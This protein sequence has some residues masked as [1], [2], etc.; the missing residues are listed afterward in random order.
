MKKEKVEAA[1]E[2]KTEEAVL[3]IRDI[4]KIEEKTNWKINLKPKTPRQC[5]QRKTERVSG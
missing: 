4:L 2:E 3:Q 1:A 5:Q